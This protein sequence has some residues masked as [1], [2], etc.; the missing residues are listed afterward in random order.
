MKRIAI[1]LLV[2]LVAAAAGVGW[3][4]LNSR[5]T[6]VSVHAVTTEAS[7]Q[8]LLYDELRDQ[9]DNGAL[10]GTVFRTGSLTGIE[11][12]QFITYTVTLRNATWL[13]AEMVELQVTPMEGDVVQVGVPVPG[14][15]PRQATGELTATLLTD[16]NAH[17]ARELTLTYYLGGVPFSL[18]TNAGR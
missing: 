13:D 1:F 12:Y 17:P 6:V 3:L 9:A 15:L 5:M 10:T 4:Y 14:T 16:I 11:H 8:P 18:R 2:L 7:A